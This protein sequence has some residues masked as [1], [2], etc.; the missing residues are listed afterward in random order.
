MRVD[1]HA[2]RLPDADAVIPVVNELAGL[3]TDLCVLNTALDARLLGYGATFIEAGCRGI[4]MR[5]VSVA[6]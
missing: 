4:P 6:D 3:A 1:L 2:R 5:A